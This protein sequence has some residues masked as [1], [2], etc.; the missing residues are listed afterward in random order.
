MKFDPMC[1]PDWGLGPIVKRP[2]NALGTFNQEGI[3]KAAKTGRNYISEREYGYVI[4]YGV[5]LPEP[6]R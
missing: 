1:A 4:V 3:R 2:W 6:F 5:D